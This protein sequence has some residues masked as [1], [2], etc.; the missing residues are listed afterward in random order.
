VQ[1]LDATYVAILA[2]IEDVRNVRVDKERGAQQAR[3]VGQKCPFAGLGGARLGDRV[4]FGVDARGARLVGFARSQAGVVYAFGAAVIA[5]AEDA[6][7]VGA[8]DHR[9]HRPSAA[10]AASS[11]LLRQ[12]HVHL[13]QG[14]AIGD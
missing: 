5:D 2:T 9:T 7:Q 10:G 14:D 11:Q 12:P 4:G 3:T 6:G 13:F 8:G 1:Q